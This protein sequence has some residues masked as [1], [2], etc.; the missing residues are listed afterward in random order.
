MR[1]SVDFHLQTLKLVVEVIKIKGTAAY[2]SGDLSF[3][4]SPV[5]ENSFSDI[6]RSIS[7]AN[8]QTGNTGSLNK[9]Q[10]LRLNVLVKCGKKCRLRCCS[11]RQ[12]VSAGLNELGTTASGAWEMQGDWVAQLYPDPQKQ[13]LLQSRVSKEQG[14]WIILC[15]YCRWQDFYA[16]NILYS[17]AFSC[18]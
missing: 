18:K 8:T 11:I 17:P 13:R 10:L 2:W 1:P 6:A 16:L 9:V 3:I 4:L 5:P 15:L 12:P 7:F 14:I